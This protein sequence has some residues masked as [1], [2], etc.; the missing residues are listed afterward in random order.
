[1][2]EMCRI[3]GK[4]DSISPIFCF[5]VC[6]TLLFPS[7]VLEIMQDKKHPSEPVWEVGC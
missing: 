4:E 6:D 3:N 7:C 2:N 1:M 5:V